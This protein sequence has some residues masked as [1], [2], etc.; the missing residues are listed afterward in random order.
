[1]TRDNTNDILKAVFNRLLIAMRDIGSAKDMNHCA[2]K[3]A[4]VE[5]IKWEVTRSKDML[6]SL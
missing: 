4:I 1:M 5:N 3:K 2:E 6:D